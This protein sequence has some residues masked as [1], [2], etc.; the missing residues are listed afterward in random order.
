MNRNQVEQLLLLAS[1]PYSV[2]LFLP[3]TRL[4]C[5]P[6]TCV[7]GIP[8]E[9]NQSRNKRLQVRPGTL[10]RPLCFGQTGPDDLPGLPRPTESAAIRSTLRFFHVRMQT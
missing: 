5:E 9:V 2:G 1:C 7:S 10:S 3:K 8:R 6:P 4:T